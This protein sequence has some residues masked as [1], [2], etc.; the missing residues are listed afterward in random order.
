M[1]TE[2]FGIEDLLNGFSPETRMQRDSLGKEADRRRE[3]FIAILGEGMCRKK[4]V[5]IR[6][7]LE[8]FGPEVK[9]SFE[10]YV[11][12]ASSSVKFDKELF[13]RAGFY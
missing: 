5:E 7:L 2:R 11:S 3:E 8:S 1:S 10:K 9:E 6:E 13:K 4:T 12:S